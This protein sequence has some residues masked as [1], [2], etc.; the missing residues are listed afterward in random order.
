MANVTK[1][2]TDQII[3]KITTAYPRFTQADRI[4]VVEQSRTL[5]VTDFA[6]DD[7]LLIKLMSA[8]TLTPLSAGKISQYNFILIYLNKVYFDRAEEIS[9]FAEQLDQVFIDNV[10]N[11]GYWTD[12]QTTLDYNSEI[13]LEFADAVEDTL[14]NKLQGFLIEI[15]LTNYKGIS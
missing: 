1:N 14:I 9:K 5:K 8:E 4:R 2:I 11:D 13:E 6:Y 10:F 12:L 7:Q 3:S 15:K